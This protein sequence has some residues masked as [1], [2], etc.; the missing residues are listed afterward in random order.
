MLEDQSGPSHVDALTRGTRQAQKKRAG[1][2]AVKNL[3]SMWSALIPRAPLLVFLG[4]KM[5][6]KFSQHYLTSAPWHINRES[7]ESMTEG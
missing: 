7:C 1:A 5:L 4:A 6:V 2:D 3:G